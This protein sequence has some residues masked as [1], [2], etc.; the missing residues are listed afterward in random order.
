MRGAHLEALLDVIADDLRHRDGELIRLFRLHEGTDGFEFV[1]RQFVQEFAVRVAMPRCQRQAVN[2][3]PGQPHSARNINGP[4]PAIRDVDRRPNVADVFRRQCGVV[5]GGL[6]ATVGW[7][8]AAGDCARPFAAGGQPYDQ[9]RK[10]DGWKREWF[11]LPHCCCL[12]SR[13]SKN[14]LSA[15][16]YGSPVT[17]SRESTAS[18]LNVRRSLARRSWASC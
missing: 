18:L 5:V 16:T 17:S 9:R 3:S 8:P 6:A 4:E 10:L 11:A 14:R 1:E 7:A 15:G 13:V 2:A 12:L